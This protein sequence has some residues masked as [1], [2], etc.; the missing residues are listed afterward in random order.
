MDTANL[1]I[2]M[3]TFL[4]VTLICWGLVFVFC[5]LSKYCK[6]SSEMGFDSYDQLIKS[7]T[8]APIPSIF[9]HQQYPMMYSFLPQHQQYFHQHH[10]PGQVY[11]TPQHQVYGFSQIQPQ[12]IMTEAPPILP[13]HQFASAS[14]SQQPPPLP[15]LSRHPIFQSRREQTKIP[16][17]LQDVVYI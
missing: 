4:A 9:Y 1:L 11:Q 15:P 8:T 16:F 7:P 10:N 5:C 14:Q 6:S 13:P 12:E 17:P 2:L 3:M